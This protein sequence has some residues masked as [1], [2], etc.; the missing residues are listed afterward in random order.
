MITY[1]IYFTTS[2]VLFLIVLVAYLLG[3]RAARKRTSSSAQAIDLGRAQQVTRQLELVV[4]EVRKHLAA[5]H[6]SVARFKDRLSEL[7]GEQQDAVWKDLCHEADEMLQPTLELASQMAGAYEEIRQQSTT[8]TTLANTDAEIISHQPLD[9][10]LQSMFAM[11]SRY[12]QPFTI[13]IFEIDNFKQINEVPGTE[14]GARTLQ[15]VAQVVAEHGRDTDFVLRYGAEELVA[16]L[17]HTTLEGACVYAERVRAT[18]EDALSITVSGGLAQALDG[19]HAQSLLSRADAA[20]YTAKAAGRNC[21]YRHT[22]RDIE[23]I[24]DDEPVS[25]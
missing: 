3:R 6:A 1:N 12:E 19:D 16:V 14:H 4:E 10:L 21:I 20:L 25:A 13:A 18:V 8:L 11:M 2:A 15:A 24:L 23:F 5:H 22:G 9:E 17:P 7:N